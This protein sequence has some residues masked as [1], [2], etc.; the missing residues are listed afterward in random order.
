MDSGNKPQFFTN[1]FIMYTIGFVLIFYFFNLRY[2]FLILL[3]L[4]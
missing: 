2:D 4:F 1:N 3:I